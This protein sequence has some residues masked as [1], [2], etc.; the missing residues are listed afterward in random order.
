MYGAESMFFLVYYKQNKDPSP[1]FLLTLELSFTLY[2][3]NDPYRTKENKTLTEKNNKNR[4]GICQT[5]SIQ[6]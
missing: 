3:Q 1:S 5:L 4:A 2:F 6:D